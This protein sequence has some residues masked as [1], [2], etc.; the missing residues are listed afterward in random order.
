MN[1]LL[2]FTVCKR[3]GK[4]KTALKLW[5]AVSVKL[6]GKAM[7]TNPAKIAGLARHESIVVRSSG[8]NRLYHGALYKIRVAAIF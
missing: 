5:P 6:P 1:F 8:P 2:H 4:R 3:S 7:A